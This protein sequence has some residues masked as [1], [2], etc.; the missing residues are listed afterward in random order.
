MTE[1]IQICANGA[2]VFALDKIGRVFLYEDRA[3]HWVQLGERRVT[4]PDDEKLKR[5]NK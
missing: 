1:F 4:E 2:G 3:R 5:V